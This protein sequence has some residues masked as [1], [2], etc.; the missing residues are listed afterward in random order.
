MH[1]H[2][3]IFLYVSANI[4]AKARGFFQSFF[5]S[6]SFCHRLLCP[7]APLRPSVHFVTSGGVGRVGPRLAG[8]LVAG[9]SWT[10][11][12]AHRLKG[13]KKESNPNAV[14]RQRWPVPLLHRCPFITQWSFLLQVPL[15]QFVSQHF[16]GF[17]F[18]NTDA[19][20]Q[21]CS[22]CVGLRVERKIKGVLA[23][24]LT[25]EFG[26]KCLQ[27]LF[28]DY[29]GLV[30]TRAVFHQHWRGQVET[31]LKTSAVWEQ[32]LFH[33]SQRYCTA[34]ETLTWQ[35][36]VASFISMIVIYITE[37]TLSSECSNDLK[38]VVELLLMWRT[39]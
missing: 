6:F 33:V 38:R 35:G 17:V 10:E 15:F 29:I 9:G 39:F 2:A 34:V 16:A 32:V 1:T 22:G 7:R 26:Q 27:C 28:L 19:S 4:M 20:N 30:Q 18:F 23:S 37:K 11:G 3:K 14:K 8:S 13:Q 31:R 25:H 24:I 5:G 21:G 12:R 36:C